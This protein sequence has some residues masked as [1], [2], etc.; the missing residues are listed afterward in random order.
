MSK[1]YSL[2]LIFYY[3]ISLD[4]CRIN[5]NGMYTNITYSTRDVLF[6]IFIPVLIFKFLF[7]TQ[8]I[9]NFYYLLYYSYN[10]KYFLLVNLVLSDVHRMYTKYFIIFIHFIVFV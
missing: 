8:E 3:L 2:K 10:I 5:L 1:K 7:Y 9:E 6:Y 4:L